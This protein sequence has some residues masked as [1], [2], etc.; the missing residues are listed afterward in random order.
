MNS[1]A[2]EL[3]PRSIRALAVAL[4]LARVSARAEWVSYSGLQALL[5]I[6]SKNGV[7]MLVKL[8]RK[9]GVVKLQREHVPGNTKRFTRALVALTQ[10]GVRAVERLAVADGN[11]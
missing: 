1:V 4:A 5:G 3:K 8:A 2:L 6:E 7:R 9:A 11:F 10:N